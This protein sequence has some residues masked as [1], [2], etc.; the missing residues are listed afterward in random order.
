MAKL[1]EIDPALLS[2]A[3]AAIG[4]CRDHGNPVA[5]DSPDRWREIAHIAIRR[6]RSFNRRGLAQRD[7]ATQLRD[8]AERLAEQFEARPDLVGPTIIDYEELAAGVL[9]VVIADKNKSP[10][11]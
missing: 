1:A 9:D 4:V 10:S 8:V 3:A 11:N 2:D 7:R 5:G 6:I